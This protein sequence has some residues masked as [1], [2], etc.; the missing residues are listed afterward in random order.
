MVMAMVKRDALNAYDVAGGQDV[1]LRRRRHRTGA[2]YG[3]GAAHHRPGGHGPRLDVPPTRL[4]AR[5]RQPTL[6]GRRPPSVG[7]VQMF[8]GIPWT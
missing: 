5:R 6:A 3:P 8:K 2:G 1:G 4:R 7:Y